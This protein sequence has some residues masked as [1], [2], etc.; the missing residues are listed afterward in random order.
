MYDNITHCQHT[1]THTLTRETEL[2]GDR[3]KPQQGGSVSVEGISMG[4]LLF[5]LA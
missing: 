3:Q 2:A 5:I 4:E 1:H